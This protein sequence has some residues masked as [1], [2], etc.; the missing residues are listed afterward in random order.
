VLRDDAKD[1]AMMQEMM[2]KTTIN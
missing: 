1:D 2:Q